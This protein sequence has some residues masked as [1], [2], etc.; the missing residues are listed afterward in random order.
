Q[1]IQKSL[2]MTLGWVQELSSALATGSAAT[3]SR[4]F[5]QWEDFNQAGQVQHLHLQHLEWLYGSV[6]RKHTRH[7]LLLYNFDV[8]QSELKGAHRSALEAFTLAVLFPHYLNV[9]RGRQ[10]FARYFETY[11][12]PFAVNVSLAQKRSLLLSQPWVG[13]V[14]RD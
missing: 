6:Y 2:H 10:G 4:G 13:D 11:E 14:G 8:A 9:L 3:R 7:V 12:Q 1:S 5:R